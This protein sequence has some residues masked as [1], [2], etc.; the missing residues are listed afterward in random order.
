MNPL[1]LYNNCSIEE[2]REQL[3][4]ETDSNNIKEITNILNAHIQKKNMVRKTQLLELEDKIQSQMEKRITEKGDCFSHKDLLDYFK[5]VDDTVNKID[6][7]EDAIVP[8]IKVT[9]QQLNIN[10]DKPT[11][12]REEKTQVVDAVKAILERVQQEQQP[13]LNNIEE[14]TIDGEFKEITNEQ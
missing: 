2:L 5:V 14:N 9:N 8:Q 3:M 11:M 12:S 13:N 10:L 7:S 4:T 6:S 1:K